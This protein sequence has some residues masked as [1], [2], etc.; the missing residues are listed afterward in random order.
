MTQPC[1]QT[2][3]A[4]I[5][6]RNPFSTR[7]LP[8]LANLYEFANRKRRRMAKRFVSKP[9]K[10]LFRF[11]YKSGIEGQGKMRLALADG[12]RDLPFN[13]RNL[14]FAALYMPE[15]A[16]GYETE[17]AALLDRLTGDDAQV[18]DIGANWG[19]Y[20][21]FLAARPGFTGHI[22]AFEP[23][24]GT[25]T[26]LSGLIGEAG[27]G[28][29]ITS[30]Q[31]GVSDT[32]GTGNMAIPG[33]M[34]L[35]GIA[36]LSDGDGV[37][38]PLLRLDDEDLPAPDV[39][40]ID[41]EGHE[42]SAF[43]GMQRILS[44]HKPWIVFES[45]L[46]PDSRITLEPLSVLAGLGYLFYVPTWVQETDHG[47]VTSDVPGDRLALIPVI[48]DQ[49]YLMSQ[50]LNLFACHQDRTGELEALYLKP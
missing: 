24:P 42:A 5:T 23:M 7:D 40:K 48:P 18:F 2:L 38:V 30:H 43:R 9:L 35:S 3:I 47:I 36:R 28:D 20:S 46:E 10:S 11:L 44:D 32:P 25:F 41:V 17:T 8:F 14:Q 34:L 39:I 26:D 15:C 33:N 31:A 16:E 37:S 4:N 45:W 27:L 6:R 22:H 49:R 29:V 19:Y 50:Q 1:P 13:A 21:L 12:A